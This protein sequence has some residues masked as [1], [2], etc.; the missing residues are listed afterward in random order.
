MLKLTPMSDEEYALYL[1]AAIKDYAQEKIEAGN[2]TSEEA[3][4]RSEQEFHKLL[5]EGPHTPN[6]HL[7]TLLD[8]DNH[9]KVGM[10]W[11]MLESGRQSAVFICDFVIDESFRRRGYGLQALAAAEEKA[12]QLGAEKISLHVFGHNH[13]ARALY[14]KA[15]Y[16][17]TNL[18][19]G[20]KL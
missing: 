10:I 2:W 6:Q 19:M 7:F 9:Q 13:A 20:K 15:G 8:E 14:E 17:V 4:Q 3:L 16:L 1:A 18:Y 11:L 12:R 5:P